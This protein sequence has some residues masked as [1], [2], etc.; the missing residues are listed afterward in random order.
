MDISHVGSHEVLLDLWENNFSNDNHFN[1]DG[2]ISKQHWDN[3]DIK[4]LFVLK[5]TNK[6]KQN[7]ITAISNALVNSSSGWWKGK[8]LR[9]IGRLAYGLINYT[10]DI[11]S[12]EEAKKH[13]KSATLNIAYINMRKTSGGART[14]EKS[15]NKHVEEY[16][17]Y[18]KKQIELISPDIV[19]LGGTYKQLKKFVYPELTRICER[20]HKHNEMIFINAFHP[21]SRTS[22]KGLYEQVL[23]SYDSYQKSYK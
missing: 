19:V 8:V 10:G 6:A 15:F 18:I 14:N 1:R 23:N 17:P 12:F 20:I 21:A 4:V 5:E 11:P 22:A 9:R 13:G 3:T 16:A 7:I 2:I